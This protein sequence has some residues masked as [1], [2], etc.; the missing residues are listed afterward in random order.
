V[1]DIG[2]IGLGIPVECIIDFV[3]HNSSNEIRN[4]VPRV[5]SDGFS[6]KDG[7]VTSE[8]ASPAAVEISCT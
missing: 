4:T 2:I 8:R 5:N 3:P 1:I 6:S 7:Q